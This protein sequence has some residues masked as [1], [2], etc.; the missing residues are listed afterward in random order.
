[1]LTHHKRGPRRRNHSSG[2]L[3]ASDIPE[4]VVLNPREYNRENNSNAHRESTER[5]KPAELAE[6]P[7]ET[8]EEAG[9]SRDGAKRDSARGR[10]CERVKKLRADKAVQ[11]CE[12]NLSALIRGSR[13]AD[14]QAYP[15]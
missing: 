15:G 3:L 1:M 5:A 13:P 10:I 12:R 8:N 4:R 6:R 14:R 2:R 11:C 9:D 7:R